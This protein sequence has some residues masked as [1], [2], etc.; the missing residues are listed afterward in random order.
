LTYVLIGQNH[1]GKGSDLAEAKANFR[2]QGAV[3]SRGYALLTFDDETEFKGVDE[4]GRYHYVGNA[5]EVK[6]FPAA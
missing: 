5:P 6:E 4:V 1:W 2:R 3:L